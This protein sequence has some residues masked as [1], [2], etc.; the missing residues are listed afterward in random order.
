MLVLLCIL[1]CW[2]CYVNNAMVVINPVTMMNR[3]LDAAD[4]DVHVRAVISNVVK[5]FILGDVL[6]M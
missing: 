2:P 1:A 3:G 4:N 6:H 5:F